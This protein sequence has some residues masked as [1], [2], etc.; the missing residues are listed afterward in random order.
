MKKLRI[1]VNG[2]V[3][4][5][6]V[7]VLQD[8]DVEAGAA[9]G[10]PVAAALPPAVTPAAAAPAPAPAPKAPAPAAGGKTLTS[11]LPGVVKA[12]KA[13]E[14]DSVKENTPLVVLEAMK[15]ETN[16]SSPVDGV[17][18]EIKVQVGQNVQQGEV[19]VVFA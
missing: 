13:K 16:I 18:K 17:V 1:T 5:V 9:L 4:E 15:M 11:P 14:G 8:D 6:D 7:E 19:L 3:Y 2:V 10:S 12:L